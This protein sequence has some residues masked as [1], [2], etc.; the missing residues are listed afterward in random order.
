MI[1]LD[2]FNAKLLI[3]KEYD[4]STYETHNEFYKAGQS[5]II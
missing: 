3:K 5:I 2:S 4:L 1:F